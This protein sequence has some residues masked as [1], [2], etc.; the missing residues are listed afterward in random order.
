MGS[1][2]S[3]IERISAL[4]PARAGIVL[5]IGDD[6]AVVAGGRATVLTQDLLV[7]GVHFR[8]DQTSA[9]DLGH[10]AIAV[11]LSDLAAMGAR[12]LAAVVGIAAPRGEL[13]DL[14]DGLYAGMDQL[15]AHFEASIVGGDITRSTE[16]MLAVAAVGT[17]PDEETAVTRDAA[18]PGDTVFVTGP[19]GGAA[20]GLLLLDEPDLSKAVSAP[21]ALRHAYCRPWPRVR[22]GLCLGEAGVSAM[23]DIS[24][25][26]LLD[27]TRM[28][29]ASEATIQIDLDAIPVAP[30]LIELGRECGFD[31]RRVAASGG[32]DY[33][34]LV[35]ARPE[36]AQAARD[37]G[38]SL[39]P[40]GR[41]LDGPARLRVTDAG[42]EIEPGDLGWE[43][44]V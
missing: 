2:L 40:V 30:G 20:G 10:K 24:D 19:L 15:A 39:T 25:G 8:R 18:S 28:G 13:A 29:A 36:S 22:E 4:T 43:H 14:L 34:L 23:M 16:L 6:A 21:D 5:G 17:L 41:V 7:D 27:A 35:S 38:V 44:D 37:A 26:L 12:P 1:E 33:E 11:N 42:I 32:D 9:R 31:S 3:M